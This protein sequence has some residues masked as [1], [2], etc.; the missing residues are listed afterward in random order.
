MAHGDVAHPRVILTEINGLFP[1]DAS[2]RSRQFLC[3]DLVIGPNDGD[4][5]C[6]EAAKEYEK[7]SIKGVQIGNEFLGIVVPGE[8]QVEGSLLGPLGPREFI[9]NGGNYAQLGVFV[10]LELVFPRTNPDHIRCLEN[11]LESDSLLADILGRDAR[12]SFR[13]LSDAAD[14]IDVLGRKSNLVAVDTEVVLGVC[15]MKSRIAHLVVVVVGVL[16][17]FEQKM[18]GLLIQLIGQP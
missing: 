8:L 16:N 2:L 1:F 15:K 18:S 5:D 13:T 6:A 7:M 11:R 12:A 9:Q 10:K 4:D 17:E 14:C 3:R